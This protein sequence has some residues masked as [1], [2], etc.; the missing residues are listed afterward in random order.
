MSEIHA[1]VNEK[2]GYPC[3]VKPNDEGSTVGLSIVSGNADTAE[4][5][6][7][8]ELA[9]SYSE[10]AVIEKFTRGREITVPVIG[11]KAFPVVEIRPKGGFYDYE[12]KYTKGMT[13]YFCPAQLEPEIESR[14]KQVSIEA[15][16][17]LGCSVYSRIDYILDDQDNLQCL[18]I[19]TLPGMTET[20]LVP[21]SAHAEGIS[22]NELVQ[23]IIDLSFKKI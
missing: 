20:S 13:D 21:K 16:K 11:N 5:T 23:M 1:L 6:K 22:F 19:N 17:A 2:I 12:H 18:E 4:L 7:A 3:V 15:H 10:K 8:I 9:F 14:A